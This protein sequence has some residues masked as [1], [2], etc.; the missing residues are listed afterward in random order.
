M[1]EVIGLL[2]SLSKQM[3][4][5]VSSQ[6]ELRERLDRL[7]QPQRRERSPGQ[8]SHDRHFSARGS[9][10]SP[11]P[12]QPYR[13]PSFQPPETYANVERALDATR[14][15]RLHRSGLDSQE[16]QFVPLQQSSKEQRKIFFDANEFKRSEPMP[17]PVVLTDPLDQIK[18]E[19]HRPPLP[20]CLRPH[21][22]PRLSR[23]EFIK[24]PPN[25]SSIWIPK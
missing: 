16:A 21:P 6:A 9:S 22:R 7:E 10:L 23:R 20:P 25:S 17:W 12:I 8:R 1:T 19:K 13:K 4:S 2:E 14:A 11:I 15:E 3:G 5:V 24:Y 18:P